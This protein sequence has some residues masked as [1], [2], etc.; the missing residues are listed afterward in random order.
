MRRRK[1][2]EFELIAKFFTQQEI[3]RADVILDI[4]DDCALLDIPADHH[5]AI[6]TDTLVNGVHFPVETSAFD[7]GYKSLAVNLSDLAAMGA[8]PA[9]V[10]LAL[11]LPSLDET[12]LAEFS[13]GFF[14]LAARHQVQLIGGD[15]THGP[16]SI[17]IT[18]QG[19]LPK[20]QAITRSGAK[21]GDFIY[22]T[23]TLG[24]AGFALLAIQNKTDL[25]PEIF[26]RL[27]RPEPRVNIG[28]KL[29]NIA[30]SA[31]DISDGLI[32]DLSHILKKSHVG[33]TIC[34][35]QLPLSPTLREMLSPEAAIAL[36]LSAGDDYE[37]C[38]TIRP[39]D[40]TLLNDTLLQ[41]GHSYTRIGT[42]TAETE[43]NLEFIDG[44]KYH[45][46]IQGYQH[47]KK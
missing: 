29:R 21:P 2:D 36:A 7:I 46:N 44:R 13:R 14:A 15:M 28:I 37:L 31:I 38:F 12:W 33:A 23:H 40:E 42:I 18:A 30:S 27:N 11:T 34:V 22:V 20:N 4:G 10:S 39:G 26:A 3:S 1:M 41:S 47:F 25:P 24:D 45:G 9:W 5:L 43:L 35:D 16:L 17:T 19:L 6:T 8:T 32:S